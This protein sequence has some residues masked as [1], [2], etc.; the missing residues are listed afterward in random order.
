MGAKQDEDEERK[1]L[2]RGMADADRSAKGLKQALKDS[3]DAVKEETKA[4]A[5]AIDGLKQQVSGIAGAGISALGER[6]AGVEDFKAGVYQGFVEA[7][8][9]LGSLLGGIVASAAGPEATA[10]GIFAGGLVGK[11]AQAGFKQTDTSAEIEAREKAIREVQGRTAP[12]AAAGVPW[13]PEQLAE[14]IGAVQLRNMRTLDNDRLARS[15][16][17]PIL[18]GR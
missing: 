14:A 4:R 18:S 1:K 2:A 8:P 12:F 6:G 13:T 3:A 10:P 16:A 9:A 17:P 5:Q 11:L 7:L 15:S